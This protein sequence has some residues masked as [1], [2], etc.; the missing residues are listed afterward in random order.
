MGKCH[1]SKTSNDIDMKPEQVTKLDKKNRELSNKFNDDIMST[2]CDFID[3]F[4][5]C[6][7][8]EAGFRTHGLSNLHFH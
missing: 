1:N 3:I 5:V 8:P 4:L 6:G 2:N 7:N